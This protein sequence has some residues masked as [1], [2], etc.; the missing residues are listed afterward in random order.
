MFPSD[1]NLESEFTFERPANPIAEAP[2]FHI[3]L[4]GDWSGEGAKKEL[5]ERRPISVDRDNFDEVIDRLNVSLNLDLNGDGNILSL[6]FTEF[7]DFHPDN[8]YRRVSLFNDLRDLRKRLSN[9]DSFNAAA[10]EVRQWFDVSDE[11]QSET[12][13]Q[14]TSIEAAPINSD[15]LLDQ[16][17]SEPR[18]NS[19]T[20]KKTDNS[21]LGQFLSKIVSPF[22]INIDETEQSKLVAAVDD[23]TGNL[24]RAILHHPQFQA[25]ESAWRGLYF[26]VK[27][28]ET[29]VDLKIFILDVSQKELTDNLKLVNSLADSFLYRLLITE[30]AETLG[31][32]SFAIVCGNY[33]FGASVDDIAA[34]MRIAKLSNSADAPFLSHIRPEIFG[35][36]SF[37]NTDLSAYRF[38][39][40]SI[41]AKLWSTLRALP[42]SESIGLSPMRFLARLPFGEQTDS[43]ETFS[44]EEFTSEPKH[45]HFLW[46][47]PCFAF[48]L[49]LAQSYRFYG[50]EDMDDRLLRDVE[51]LPL[52]VYSKNGETFTEP[53]AEVVLTEGLSETILGQGLIPL[54]SFRDSDNVRLG[55]WQSVS[56]PLKSLKGSWNK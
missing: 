27:R 51:V 35:A 18:E 2:P 55:R 10:R 54:L 14:N 43:V 49:L 26:L 33:S 1:T 19:A 31:G 7:D 32:D 37:D 36:K 15:N 9:S 56:D 16:I 41:E 6:D 48:A 29:D 23:A 3:L 20:S 22:L 39:D 13:D 40:Q 42:E 53:C 45:E 11:N 25:L 21:E 47:N 50:W 46:S 12:E 28:V 4:L 24:M 30:T 5:S 44:F 8:L 17:L 34:L 38:S 52:Y